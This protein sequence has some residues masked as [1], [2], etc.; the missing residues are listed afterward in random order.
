MEDAEQLCSRVDANSAFTYGC[1]VTLAPEVSWK[2]DYKNIKVEHLTFSST[3][4]CLA[5]D[6]LLA[7]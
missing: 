1:K 4:A 5:I 6:L 2:G 3:Q 7:L